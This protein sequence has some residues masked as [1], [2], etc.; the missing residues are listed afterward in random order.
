VHCFYAVVG[1][2]ARPGARDDLCVWAANRIAARKA[3]IVKIVKVRPGE[4]RARIV[5]EVTAGGINHTPGGRSIDLSRL[6][7][8]WTDD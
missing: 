5:L 1:D 4:A 3:K 2:I 8:A 7:K 6:K